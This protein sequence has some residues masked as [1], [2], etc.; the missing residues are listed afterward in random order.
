MRQMIDFRKGRVVWVCVLI[1][2]FLT[3]STNI[4]YADGFSDQADRSLQGTITDEAGLPIE[5]ADVR[6]GAYSPET[7]FRFLASAATD[8]EG[9]YAISYTQSVYDAV[10]AILTVNSHVIVFEVRSDTLDFQLPE[11]RAV[12]TG[13]ITY[14]DE[15]A[16]PV[17][18][19]PISLSVY[20]GRGGRIPIADITTDY[21]GN[22]SFSII[23]GTFQTAH[24]PNAFEL[25]YNHNFPEGIVE[26]HLG[27][28]LVRDKQ[29]TDKLPSTPF[30][31]RLEV[32]VTDESDAPV[33]NAAVELAGTNIPLYQTGHYFFSNVIRGGAYSLKVTAPGY[34]P[35]EAPI[36]INGGVIRKSLKLVRSDDTAPVTEAE[37]SEQ[38][39]SG[40]WHNTDVH[41]TLTAADN[42][43]GVE[44]T[45]Y[46]L[47][48]G[49]TWRVYDGGITLSHE[50]E[51]T[52]LYRSQDKAGNLE[53]EKQLGVK[54]DKTAPTLELALNRYTLSPANHKMVPIRAIVEGSDAGAG[55]ESIQ[56]TSITVSDF[57][58]SPK[59]KPH[60]SDIQ[61]A[62]Y[63]TYDTAFQLRAEIAGKGSE[64]HYTILYTAT[65]KAGNQSTATAVVKVI[66]H[67]KGN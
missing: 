6:V 50:G 39:R 32:D 64:R 59:S 66:K 22:Y 17:S 48:N 7:G 9:K 8:A 56:L 38:P 10:S 58:H 1:A 26:F 63:G 25:V 62:E 34:L 43:S 18:Q 53:Q 4:S 46:S 5:G 57:K 14:V 65:D 3:T 31:G 16:T 37:V 15:F 27:D 60:E 54:I 11:E 47:D 41:V 2:A 21:D 40:G 36:E 45:T 35:Q 29:V 30:N 33:E 23:P 51:H 67:K 20:L 19:Y 12:I 52:L 44:R 42:Q 61:N 24:G 55:I 49:S 13:N 28:R